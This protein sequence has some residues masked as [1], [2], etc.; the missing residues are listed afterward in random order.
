MCDVCRHMPCRVHTHTYVHIHTYTHTYTYAYTLMQRHCQD[1]LAASRVCAHRHDRAYG[2][3][4]PTVSICPALIMCACVCM[5]LFSGMNVWASTCMYGVFHIWIHMYVQVACTQVY[6]SLLHNE[7]M[8]MHAFVHIHEFIIQ[9]HTCQKLHTQT[10]HAYIEAQRQPESI[11]PSMF[12]ASGTPTHAW[13]FRY[14]LHVR[15]HILATSANTIRHLKT[16]TRT[17][18]SFMHS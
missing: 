11:S 16:Y 8:R 17:P 1:S 7:R 6:A 10:H 5:C 15:I 13:Q 9:V 3:H 18:F 14:V 2:L 12:R 4:R